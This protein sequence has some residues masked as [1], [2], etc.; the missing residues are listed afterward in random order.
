M[1]NLVLLAMA[2][3]LAGAAQTTPSNPSDN[4]QPASSNPAP[5]AM[6]QVTVP[7]G[8]E[9]LLQL[10]S[11]IDTKNAQVGDGVYCQT[12]FPVSIDNV[13]VI[14]AGTYVKGQIVKV[15][16]AARV[17][18]RAEVLFRFNSIIFPNRYNLDIP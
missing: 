4:C 11:S 13:I 8:T 2:V 12:S 5:A 18:R 14:P 16:R 6:R 7:A 15:Q 3:S 10:K 9:V 17:K 1:R